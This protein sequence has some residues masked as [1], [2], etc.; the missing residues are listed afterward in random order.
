MRG[1]VQRQTHPI[2]A[3]AVGQEDV[4]AGL[5]E[6]L[7]HRAQLCRLLDVPKLGRAAGLEAAREQAGAHRAIGEQDGLGREQ[8]GEGIHGLG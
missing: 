4:A 7:V 1:A 2:G 3:K 8:A 5:D 6:A